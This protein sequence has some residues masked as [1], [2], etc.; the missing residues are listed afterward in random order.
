[1][2]NINLKTKNFVAKSAEI[3]NSVSVFT[4]ILYYLYLI[5]SLSSEH[6]SSIES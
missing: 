1:M 5:K 6:L 3:E 2:K 4:L